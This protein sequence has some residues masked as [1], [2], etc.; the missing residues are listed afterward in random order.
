MSSKKTKKEEERKGKQKNGKVKRRKDMNV[1][2]SSLYWHD[3][4]NKNLYSSADCWN[5][6]KLLPITVDRLTF[7]ISP[8]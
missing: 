3:N 1:G 2:D 7:H 6:L 5:N 4:N 8:P